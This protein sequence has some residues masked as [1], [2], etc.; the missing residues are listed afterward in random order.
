[1]QQI[2]SVTSV[3]ASRRKRSNS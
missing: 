3:Q 2:S 1:M